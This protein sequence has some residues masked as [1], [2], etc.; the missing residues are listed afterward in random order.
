MWKQ[1]NNLITSETDL[2][3][4]S[5]AILAKQLVQEV[6]TLQSKMTN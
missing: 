6:F 5:S 3:F 2:I 4:D 1:L